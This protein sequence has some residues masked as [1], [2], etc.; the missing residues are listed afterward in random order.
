MW[1]LSNLPLPG[2]AYGVAFWVIQWIL[3]ALSTAI[4]WLERVSYFH[5]LKWDYR[6]GSDWWMDL[7]TT[8]THDSELQALTTL[9]LI[10]AFYKSLHA[11]F[12]PAFNVFTSRCLVTALNNGEFSTSVLASLLPDEYPTTSSLLKSKSKLLYDRRFAANLFILASSSLRLTKRDFFNWT[13]T[14]IVHT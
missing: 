5:D 6:R 13:L 2:M 1:E 10:S 9:S 14:V 8:Y 12:S 3:V 11:K 4:K 7:L